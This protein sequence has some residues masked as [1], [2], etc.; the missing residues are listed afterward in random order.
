MARGARV[1]GGTASL[2]SST[3]RGA[4]RAARWLWG[5]AAYSLALLPVLT[6]WVDAGHWP[7]HPRELATEISMGVLI[8]IGVALLYR[9]GDHFRALAVT[10]ALT[11]L[12]NRLRFR[13]DIEAAV[14]RCRQAGQPLAIAF[15]DVDRFKEI[16]DRWGHDAGDEALRE[17]ARA[18]ERSVRQGI[19]G[20][21]RFGGDEFA[22]LLPGS[23]GKGFL[24]A[25]GR[26]FAK[27][28]SRGGAS[29]SCSVGVVAL[30]DEETPGDIVRRAD[31]LMYEAKRGE[32]GAVLPRSHRHGV[33]DACLRAR[34]GR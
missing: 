7:E 19:D 34:G 33:C 18:L 28:S 32:I 31:D 1:A 2:P 20:C 26:S 22:I 30:R 13:G 23:D 25:L 24:P 6:D 8:L 11:G 3:F 14:A 10:D 21:Y 15:V 27:L 17:I 16:N 5:R 4:S 12:G 29:I 9:R